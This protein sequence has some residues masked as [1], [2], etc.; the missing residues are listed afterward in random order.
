MTPSKSKEL[1][2]S[3]ETDQ[4]EIEIDR[5]MRKRGNRLTKL[6]ER[7]FSIHIPNFSTE[8]AFEYMGKTYHLTG[9][10]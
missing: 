8:I 4:A 9:T 6:G 5:E 3:L 2:L 7:E 1:K 10:L